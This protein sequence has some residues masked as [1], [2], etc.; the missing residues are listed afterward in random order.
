MKP[1]LYNP[2]EAAF[3]LKHIPSIKTNNSVFVLFLIQ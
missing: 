2:G 3:P 1:Q